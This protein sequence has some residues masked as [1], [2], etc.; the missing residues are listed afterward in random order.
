MTVVT[1]TEEK[2]KETTY[3]FVVGEATFTGMRRVRVNDFL[4]QYEND[5]G[6]WL[7]AGYE[8]CLV[9]D[10]AM[11]PSF[12][13]QVP[14]QNRP[15]R[16]LAASAGLL[17]ALQVAGRAAGVRRE[18]G[19]RLRDGGGHHGRDARHR[20]V[21]RRRAGDGSRPRSDAGIRRRSGERRVRLH[22]H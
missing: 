4:I 1:A 11:L 21:L 15:M 9:P 18:E 14:S 2:P 7:L 22:L 19:S 10:A 17:R 16:I 13:N 6:E 12:D 20:D 3:S 8:N 5:A